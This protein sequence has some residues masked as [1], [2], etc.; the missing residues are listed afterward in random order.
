[1]TTRLLLRLYDFLQSHRF[2]RLALLTAV[3]VAAVASALQLRFKEDISDFLPNDPTYRRSM[4]LYRQ[5]NVADRIFVVF[6]MKDTSQVDVDRI[7]QAVTLFEQQAKAKRWT[8]TARMDYERMLRVADFVYRNAPLL[9]NE[10]DYARMSRRM[11]ADSIAAAVRHDKE[12]LLFPT[13]DWLS[14]NI[15]KD[16]LGLFTPILERLQTSGRAMRYELNDGCIFAPGGRFAI[17]MVDSPFGSSETDRNNQL[18]EEIDAATRKVEAQLQNVQITT[19]GAPVIA[20]ENA[21]QIKTDSLW[22]VGIAVVLILGLLVYTLRRV[23]YLSLIALSLAFGWVVAMGGIALVSREVSIIVLGIAS[24]I[25]GIAVN[26]P[27]HFVT[28]LGHCPSP[29]TTLEEIAEP[30]VVGNITTVGAFC[31][32]I[33]LDSTALRDLGL[34]AAFMLVGTICFVVVFLPHLCGRAK[35]KPL[36]TCDKDSPLEEAEQPTDDTPF[37]PSYPRNRYLAAGLVVATIVLGYFSWSTQFDTDMQKINYLKDAQKSLLLELGHMRNELPGTTQVYFAATGQTV[38]EAL[39]RSA[40]AFPSLLI[41]GKTEQQ[42]RIDRWNDFVARYRPLLK[43]RLAA[44]AFANGFSKEAFAD[45]NAVLD[46][47]YRPQAVSYFAPL[48][49][50]SLGNRIVGN[51]VVNILNVPSAQADSLMAAYNNAANGD[52]QWAFDV[53]SMNSAIAT[54]LSQHF[55]YIGW[56]CGAIVFVFLWLSFR[57]IELTLIAFLPMV[58]SWI[59]ILGTMHLLDMRF[60]LVNIILA[61]FIFGQG[62]DYSIFITEGLIYEQKH[63]RRMLASYKRSIFLSAAIMFIGMGSLVVARHPALHSLGEITIVG[64]ASVV[65]LTYLIPPMLFGWLYTNSD[66]TARPQPITLVRLLSTAWAA[67]VYLLQV[68]YGCL[69]G[70]WLFVLH[71]KTVHRMGIFHRQKYHFFRFDIQH[72]PGVKTEICY[73]GEE[74][75][76][77]PAVIICNHQSILDPVCLM[78]LSPH[79]LISIGSRVWHHPLV[80]RVLRFADFIPTEN[81]SEAILSFCRKHVKNGYSIAIFPE[82][83]RV[84]TSSISRFHNGAFA[85][86]KELNVDILPVYLYGLRKLMPCHSPVCYRGKLIIRVGKRITQAELQQMGNTTLEVKRAVYRRY[87]DE[88]N[89]FPAER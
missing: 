88:Y 23:R 10:E 26:Y 62:D 78:A 28:H 70:M 19:T 85:L 1:M 38:E 2:L 5:T 65:V 27:L 54:T 81:G 22:A 34:F 13:G 56:V 47:R 59:W 46:T 69:L 18:I 7:V 4:D 41:A 31:A 45:F 51:T 82:G 30:L 53:Q 52:G 64:M 33:P 84:T 25:I 20:V 16:P 66:G 15:Q 6:R 76:N 40:Q 43:E 11:N 89:A 74:N 55:N 37:T 57:R 75:F 49:A 44:E 32:L 3:M 73:D 86:A 36:A 35:D 79:I 80:A 77:R 50:N 12:M 67:A 58:V 61:T 39:E 14:R 87:V 68:F 71:R 17:A 72:L 63:R 24:V 48:T 42:R 83:E 8:I 9:M 60:N 29:R 21:R